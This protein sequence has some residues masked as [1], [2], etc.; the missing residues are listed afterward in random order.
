V[1][2]GRD[3]ESSERF[4]GDWG[5]LTRAHLASSTATHGVVATLDGHILGATAAM[6]RL[7][8]IPQRADLGLRC[9]DAIACAKAAIEAPFCGRSLRSESSWLSGQSLWNFLTPQSVS[10]LRS[11]MAT[12]S[13]RPDQVF[14]M[15][16]TGTAGGTQLLICNLD[17]QPNAFAMLC[18]PISIL[19]TSQ[20]RLRNLIGDEAAK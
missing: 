2:G 8:G 1:E 20:P 11:R 12:G 13:R 15:T 19:E 14:T 6:E 17:V 10:D 16:F 3:G 18:E 9:N 5:A 4:G 7:L